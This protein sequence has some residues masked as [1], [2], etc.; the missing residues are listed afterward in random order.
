[1]PFLGHVAF[2]EGK[3]ETTKPLLN[4]VNEIMSTES[5]DYTKEAMTETIRFRAKEGTTEDLK[6]IAKDRGFDDMSDMIRCALLRALKDA[7][8][9][10]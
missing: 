1:M 2:I 4:V 8:F 5:S 6:K 7:T 9:V 3:S 10:K